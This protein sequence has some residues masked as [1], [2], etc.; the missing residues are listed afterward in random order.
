MWDG[1]KF[2]HGKSV[3]SAMFSNVVSSHE[4]VVMLY[5]VC[6]IMQYM[7]CPYQNNLTFMLKQTD[8]DLINVQN[9]KS[10]NCILFIGILFFLL[11]RYGMWIYE[12]IHFTGPWTGNFIIMVGEPS[13]LGMNYTHLKWREIARTFIKMK[14]VRRFKHVR[15]KKEI[16]L[17][18]VYTSDMW[19]SKLIKLLWWHKSCSLKS[20]MWRKREAIFSR[21]ASCMNSAIYFLQPIITGLEKIGPSFAFSCKFPEALFASEQW[22]VWK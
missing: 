1:C 2:I 11:R 10:K 6:F 14:W 22:E 17:M 15:N 9:D 20:L 18:V 19:Y 3:S 8:R 7:H 13:S 4:K 21:E 12:R 16:C 5:F